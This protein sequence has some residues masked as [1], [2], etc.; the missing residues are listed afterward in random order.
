VAYSLSDLLSYC[1]QIGG[2]ELAVAEGS[3]PAVRVLGRMMVIP[4]AEPVPVGFVARHLDTVMGASAL[5]EL[6]AQGR[7]GFRGG[8]WLERVW[9]VTL[10]RQAL[11]A[12]A[13]FKPVPLA[14]PDLASLGTPEAM[15]ALL[16]PT[17]GLVLFSGPACCGKTTTAV[18]LTESLCARRNLRVRSLQRVPEFRLDAGASLLLAP[19]GDIDLDEAIALGIKSGTDVFYLGDLPLERMDAVLAAAESGAMVVATLR[20]NSM[21][22]VM[23]RILDRPSAV[24]RERLRSLLALYLRAVV[25]QFLVPDRE[26][27]A[28]LPAWEVMYHNA[29]I[30]AAIRAGE[31][32]RFPQIL[33][34]G[35]SEGMLP[36]DESLLQL[37]NGGRVDKK[38]VVRLA[39]EPGRFQ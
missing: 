8:P 4:G 24:E 15:R 36:L 6:N 23:D 34:T 19:E 18:A 3:A 12:V 39:F 25:L 27:R 35:V 33:R 2:A 9:R 37:V 11:G 29:S 16:V 30:A 17:P 7:S 10:A 28:A 21:A 22:G 5:A 26:N 31:Y 1:L 20:A 14:V 32:Y 38:E 13:Y